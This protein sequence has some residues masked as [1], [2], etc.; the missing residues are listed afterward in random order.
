MKTLDEVRAVLRRYADEFSYA[1]A[2][3]LIRQLGHAEKLKDVPAHFLDRLHY[4]ATA[5]LER[6]HHDPVVQLGK[7]S[8]RL[9]GS[10]QAFEKLRESFMA[11]LDDLKAAAA[12]AVTAMSNA[13]T[14]LQNHPA[15]AD[16]AELESLATGLHNAAQALNA[17]TGAGSTSGTDTSSGG[18]VDTG[19]TVNNGGTVENTGTAGA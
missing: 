18:A 16:D 3:D 10:I 9:E 8:A 5:I 6:R 15:A 12:E 2:R 11:G 4:H 14:A 7:A 17:A 19:G 13:A 1:E